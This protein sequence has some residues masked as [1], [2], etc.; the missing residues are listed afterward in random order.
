MTLLSVFVSVQA[1]AYDPVWQWDDPDTCLHIEDPGC[2][3]DEYNNYNIIWCDTVTLSEAISADDP[4]T[5]RQALN[6]TSYS[7]SFGAIITA[8]AM[9][10]PGGVLKMHSNEGH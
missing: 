3:C 5:L 10:A 6:M 4:L 8:D 9:Q 2:E 7:S 1:F